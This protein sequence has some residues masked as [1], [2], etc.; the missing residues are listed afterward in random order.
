MGESRIPTLTAEERETK[1]QFE[2]EYPGNGDGPTS[3]RMAIRAY[4]V[5]M[6]VLGGQVSNTQ[7][8]DGAVSNSKLDRVSSDRI[9]VDTADIA[10]A[11]ITSAKIGSAQVGTVQIADASITNAKLTAFQQINS[12]CR[13][14]TLRMVR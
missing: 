10:D 7:I 3:G 2:S 8:G 6:G 11:V 1:S 9:V 5:T 13:R 4:L 14:Q 12:W